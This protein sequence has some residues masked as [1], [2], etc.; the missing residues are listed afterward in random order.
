VEKKVAIVQS[1]Y[2]PWKGY[3][4]LIAKADLFIFHDDL[5]YTKQDWRNRNKIKTPHGPKWLSIPCGSNENRLICKVVLRDHTWQ[6]KHWH[7]IMQSYQFA[8]HFELYKAFFEEFYLQ[9]TWT[10]LSDLNQFLIKKISRVY[11]GI[12][13]E[14]DDSRRYNLKEK[15]ALRVLELLKKVGADI[16]LSGPKAK[17]Y[18]DER[19]FEDTGIQI[20]WMDY[21]GYPKYDQLYPPFE[22]NVSI[23][24]LLF[25]VGEGAKKYLKCYGERISHGD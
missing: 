12:N 8:P 25:S 20:E 11:L 19:V 15:K 21:N 9:G 2:I 23:I 17:N 10:N 3:F 1:N 5:Q 7:K 24:D 4:D 13:T 6:R 16:Y 14:F 22:H 18:L